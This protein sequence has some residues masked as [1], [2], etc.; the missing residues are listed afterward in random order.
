MR[1]TLSTSLFSA[2]LLALPGLAAAQQ[3][4]AVDTTTIAAAVPAQPA[5]R[6][7]V[8]RIAERDK[9]PL[10]LPALYMSTAVLQGLD[11]Y[12]TLN[13]LSHGAVEANPMARGVVGHPAAFVAVK[14]AM[15]ALSVYAAE[16]TWKRNKAGA[17]A[18]L[19]V[20]NSVTAY[21]VK[22]NMDVTRNLR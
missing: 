14:G 2:V 21:V 20:S 16:K 3:A 1:R 18:L 15:A 12:T 22:H 8:T 7:M 10:I 13:G 6:R 17:V 9:R 5:Q 4:K 19:I 11:A